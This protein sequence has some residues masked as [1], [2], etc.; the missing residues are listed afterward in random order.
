[1]PWIWCEGGGRELTVVR[2]ERKRRAAGA[3]RSKSKSRE[4]G[5]GGRRMVRGRE[6]DKREGI[7]GD[8][9]GTLVEGAPYV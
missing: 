2:R 5:W 1:M 7:R 3:S 9:N 4:V 6:R 8:S